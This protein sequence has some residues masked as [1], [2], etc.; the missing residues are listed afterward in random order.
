MNQGT[1]AQDFSVCGKSLQGELSR[2]ASEE[3]EALESECHVLDSQIKKSKKS[4]QS[5]SPRSIVHTETEDTKFTFR[6][7]NSNIN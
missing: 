2:I 6:E 3:I 7:N 1:N 5:N 4:V